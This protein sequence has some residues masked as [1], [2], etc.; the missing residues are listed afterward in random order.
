MNTKDIKVGEEYAIGRSTYATPRQRARVVALGVDR[1]VMSTGF[2]TGRF[3]QDGIKLEYLLDSGEPIGDKAARSQSYL[4]PNPAR[5]VNI[6]QLWSEE[7]ASLDRAVVA[8]TI[9]KAKVET[10]FAQADA[11]VAEANRSI[12]FS[13]DPDEGPFFVRGQRGG[14]AFPEVHV[15]DLESLATTLIERQV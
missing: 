3:A 5:A 2:G 12:G 10:A 6:I 15:D 9:R 4:R 1:R 7:Q 13:G 11:L 8:T 14:R